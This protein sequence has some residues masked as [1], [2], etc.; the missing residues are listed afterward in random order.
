MDQLLQRF[1]IHELCSDGGRDAQLM[2]VIATL[3][4]MQGGHIL[5]TVDDMQ[6]ALSSKELVL[7]HGPDGAEP[8]LEITIE[9]YQ[10]VEIN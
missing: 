5:L 8:S 9:G 2:A 1:N 3:V 6:A 7:Q 4:H 10:K